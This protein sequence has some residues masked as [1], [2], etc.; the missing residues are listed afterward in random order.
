V[1]ETNPQSPIQNPK[2]NTGGTPVPQGDTGYPSMLE[3]MIGRGEFARV[4]PSP[5]AARPPLP[6]DRGEG[7]QIRAAAIAPSHRTSDIPHPTSDTGGTPVPRD[8]DHREYDAAMA[9]MAAAD[10]AGM[11]VK[12]LVE[13]RA[14]LIAAAALLRKVVE[15][16][17]MEEGMKAMNAAGFDL[18]CEKR[19][20][21]ECGVPCCTNVRHTIEARCVIAG[22]RS[23]VV[24]FDVAEPESMG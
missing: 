19:G 16:A 12:E 14:S 23:V 6:G 8:A 2:C 22:G 3:E 13:A 1:S 9:S 21:C 4:I 18:M 20:P 5:V 17:G 11:A 10:L 7:A 15:A 24:K